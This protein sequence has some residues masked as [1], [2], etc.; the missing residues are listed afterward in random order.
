M[1]FVFT[2]SPHTTHSS[3]TQ[4]FPEHLQRRP[5]FGPWQSSAPAG[6]TW[7]ART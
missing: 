5:G 6:T 7:R 3:S 2:M 1:L 4:A